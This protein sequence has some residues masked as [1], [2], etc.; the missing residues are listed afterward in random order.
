MT[1]RVKINIHQAL[2]PSTTQTTRPKGNGNENL[3]PNHLSPR[4][5]RSG[6]PTS[7]Q[8]L[9]QSPFFSR[10]HSSSL[11]ALLSVSPPVIVNQVIHQQGGVYIPRDPIQ[12]LRGDLSPKS[13]GSDDESEELGD[14]F[15]MDTKMVPRI[16]SHTCPESG[17]RNIKVRKARI[18]VNRRPPSPPAFAAD[19]SLLSQQVSS[20]VIKDKLHIPERKLD[21]VVETVK[22]GSSDEDELINSTK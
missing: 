12:P 14:S 2:K 15:Q 21:E 7:T 5:S 6:S 17:L 3:S 22:E 13:T 18:K 11:E 8:S 10:K 9:P 1:D 19:I 20:L 4:S 16:R